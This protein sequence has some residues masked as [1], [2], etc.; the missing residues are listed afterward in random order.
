MIRMKERRGICGA[1]VGPAAIL[2]GGVEEEEE[3][4]EV[5]ALAALESG[6]SVILCLNS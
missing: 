6:L 2:D 1:A 4:E 3:E 5:D